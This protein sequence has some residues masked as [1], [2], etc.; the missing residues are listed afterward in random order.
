MKYIS[1]KLI[2]LLILVLLQFAAMNIFS[3][4]WYNLNVPFGGR[5]IY[6]KDPNNVIVSR[7]KTTNAGVNWVNMGMLSGG[8]KMNFPN[9]NTGYAIFVTEVNKT[10]NFGDNWVLYSTP[11]TYNLTD[12]T[13]LDLN[14][15]YACGEQ[16]NIIKTT[17]GG[18]NWTL[19]QPL[20]Q[21][22]LASYNFI[23]LYF[24]DAL[25]G[26]IAGS[27]PDSN[28]FLR[29]TNGGANWLI[30]YYV[31]G[32]NIFGRFSCMFFVN[33][34]TGYIGSSG[35]PARILRTTNSGQGWNVN[36][37]P[38][39][40]DI[41]SIHFPSASTGYA[42]CYGGQILKTTNNG[43][44]W[45][46]QTTGTGSI[47]YSIFFIN[48]LTGYCSGSDNTVLKTTDGGGPPIGITPL[49]SEIPI[50]YG[51]GQNYPNPFNPVT[52]FEFKIPN[53]GFITVEIFDP[54]GR[55][56][57]TIVNDNF[58]PGTYKVDWNA[59]AYPSG[60]YFYRLKAGDFSQ[61]KKMVLVK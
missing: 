10:T 58:S 50:D 38:T 57:E 31:G 56:V 8:N 49:S 29:T 51:L 20:P 52:S 42:S 24:T 21:P 11:A 61:T 23:G 43:N 32:I 1:N 44:S 54:L 55:K 22:A 59:S 16:G 5:G 19:F 13:F 53:S 28:I 17:N 34:S 14:T 46:L 33:S 36:F 60:V 7:F 40:N 15:G 41:Y 39:G 12:I 2:K 45:F 27:R 18:V 26:W 3:Q 9:A 25:T 30:T 48:D 6:M 37:L 35:T 47:L 4:G